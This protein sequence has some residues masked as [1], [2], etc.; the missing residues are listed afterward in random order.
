MTHLRFATLYIALA[1]LILPVVPATPLPVYSAVDMAL[2]RIVPLVAAQLAVNGTVTISGKTLVGPPT[3]SRNVVFVGD[4]LTYGYTEPGG[5]QQASNYPA[6]TV[7]Q[8]A[9]AQYAGNV[10]NMGVSGYTVAQMNTA[11]AATVD[12]LKVAGKT[13]IIVLMGGANDIKVE[14]DAA[15]TY[16]R[17]TTY[18]AARKTA[19]WDKVVAV[20]IAA[21]EWPFS[22]CSCEAQRIGATAANASIYCPLCPGTPCAVGGGEIGVNQRIRNVGVVPSTGYDALVDLAGIAAF[23]DYTNATYYQPADYR[24]HWQVALNTLAAAQV[25]A[26]INAL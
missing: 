25:A 5:A 26:A 13:N 18:W 4:S 12:V 7:P 16:S 3:G 10:N 15:T 20:T 11:A 6:L 22:W 19:T 2:A 8:L 23:Q 14:T 17:I 9:P 1:S 21:F 24:I